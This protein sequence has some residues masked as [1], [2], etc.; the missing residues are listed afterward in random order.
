MGFAIVVIGQIGEDRRSE[1]RIAELEGEV[2]PAL[3]RLLRPSRPDIGAFEDEMAG[4]IVVGLV[5]L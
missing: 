5:G 1:A 3:V 2:G 4:G